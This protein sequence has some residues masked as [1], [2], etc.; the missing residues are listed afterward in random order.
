MQ[1]MFFIDDNVLLGVLIS[2]TII[3]YVL[4]LRELKSRSV[5]TKIPTKR[6]V[7]VTPK[8]NGQQEKRENSRRAPPKQENSQHMCFHHFGY[9]GDLPRSG[10][11]PD[12]CLG[13]PK[14]VQCLASGEAAEEDSIEQE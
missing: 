7:K 10:S 2:I 3:A 11:L 14:V 9:L 1:G 12:E 6:L 8:R 13:C 5:S 4:V